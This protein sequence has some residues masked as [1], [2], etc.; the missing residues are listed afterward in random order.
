MKDVSLE[1]Y[2]RPTCS[3]CQDAKAFLA[4]HETSYIEY[5]LSE[6]PDKEKKLIKVSGARIV[7]AFVF[8]DKSPV[9]FLRKPT[10]LIGFAQNYDEIIELLGR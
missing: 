4:K 8:K 2:T 1:L 9:R 7:P 6:Q 10:V 5:D 3:D